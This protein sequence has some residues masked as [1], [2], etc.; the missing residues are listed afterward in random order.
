[1]KTVVE[2]EIFRPI[3][4]PYGSWIQSDN[5]DRRGGVPS[6]VSFSLKAVKKDMMRMLG[7]TR[8]QM[9]GSS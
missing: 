2:S 9:Q 8:G 3:W 5:K 6:Y 7:F 4:T 1:M